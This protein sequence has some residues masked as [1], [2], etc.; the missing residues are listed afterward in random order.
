VED[1]HSYWKWSIYGWVTYWPWWFSIVVPPS[2]RAKRYMEHPQCRQSQKQGKPMNF[3]RYVTLLEGKHGDLERTPHHKPSL[4]AINGIHNS[5]TMEL[6]QRP[7]P[8][9]GFP[10]C[11]LNPWDWPRP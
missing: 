10:P 1:W 8:L 7:A 9:A 4:T 6:V 3:H 2:K 11:M 5:P